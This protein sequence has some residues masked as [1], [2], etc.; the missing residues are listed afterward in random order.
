MTAKSIAQRYTHQRRTSW[1]NRLLW[2]E[3]FWLLGLAP[4]LLFTEY[5]W[6]PVLRP[7][8]IVA[9]FL[10][11][12]LRLKAA[13]GLL[14]HGATGWFVGFLLL[15]LPVTLWRS[16]G[17]ALSWEAAGYSYLALV[18][19]VAL[20]HWPPLRQQ[21]YWLAL[22]LITVGVA[23]AVV[24]PE[25]FAVNPDKMLDIYQTEE[26][27]LVDPR[28]EGETINPNIL[29]AAL[30]LILPL[31]LALALC[32]PWVRWRWLPLLWASILI[33]G[34]G[35][36]LSQ[37]RSSWLA[38][39]VAGLL[40]GWL[41]LRK[42]LKTLAVLRAS[43]TGEP[44]RVTG[45]HPG[46]PG[47]VGRW[48]RWIGIVSIG[49]LI[50][51]LF[52]RLD[53]IMG[54]VSPTLLASTQASLLRRLDIWRLSLQLLAAKPL[55]GIGLGSYEVVFATAFPTLPLVG[56]RLAP[57]HAHNLFLQLALDLGLPGLVAFLGLL[58][59]LFR[60]LGHRLQRSHRRPTTHVD[61]RATKPLALGVYCALV[62]LLVVGCFDNAL[63]GTKLT[64]IPW[65][66]FAL[67][68]LVGE[69]ESL[70]ASA[71]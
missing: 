41:L 71:R 66:L 2:W 56:G 46:A 50:G 49:L 13:G 60:S 33:M 68:F 12:P 70:H 9:L 20:I 17:S 39:G 52:W 43:V 32:G 24:G 69:G 28:L 3:P 42:Q 22:L 15:W 1:L 55:T 64:F 48:G 38:L 21:P 58:A 67:A 10:F 36:L 40:L 63:W 44:G 23:L 31:G 26:F 35:L 8:L 59:L 6:E 16:T 53:T 65:L 45:Y 27:S 54:W 14:P 5:F 25:A 19:F 11:W 29:G 30:G 51:L 61:A 18:S 47:V 37:S 34:N 7:L 57:P 4:S 62:A